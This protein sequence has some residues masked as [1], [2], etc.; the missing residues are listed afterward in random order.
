MKVYIAVFIMGITVGWGPCLAFCAPV[1]LPYIAATRKG[2]LEGLKATLAF[3]I[4]RIVP[5]AILGSIS[6]AL[7]QYLIRNFY[8]SRAV[9]IIQILAA[10]F[11]L[12]AGLVIIVGKSPHLR[13]CRA[14]SK[15]IGQEGVKGMVLL[16][17]LIGMLPCMPLL[18][19]LTYITLISESFL[20]GM[21][22]G[23]TFGVGTLISPLILFGPLA[24]G[25][26]SVLFKKPLIYKIFTRACGL[27]LIYLGAG[28]IIRIFIQ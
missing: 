26:S 13:I 24:A 15:H 14:L 8:Q 1:L 23:L 4:S 6:A 27:V 9:L 22:L 12:L 28:M 25:A 3:S 18:G 19:L 2:W 16:G 5:Y 21:F 11:I 10:G 20:H 7:G 17:F